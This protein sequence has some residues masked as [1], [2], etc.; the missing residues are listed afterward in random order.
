MWDNFTT[1]PY[2]LGNLIV[3][4]L[5]SFVIYRVVNIDGTI[6]F[7]VWTKGKFKSTML[8]RYVFIEITE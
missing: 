4:F 8:I 3:V 1:P 7:L 6:V 5:L 2:P